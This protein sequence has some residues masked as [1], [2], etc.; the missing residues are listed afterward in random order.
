MSVVWLRGDELRCCE[1]L[2]SS[3]RF[4][5]T[6]PSTA[7][8]AYFLIAQVILD[9]IPYE[10]IEVKRALGWDKA[11]LQKLGVSSVPSCYLIYPN[12]SHGLVTV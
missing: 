6:L 5:R 3:V 11:F 1:K 7:K 12:G 4:R 9:L 8:A 10:N 2:R